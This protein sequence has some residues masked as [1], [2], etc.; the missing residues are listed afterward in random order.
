MMFKQI[1]ESV[2]YKENIDVLKK[3]KLNWAIRS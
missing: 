3:K 1:N 2:D